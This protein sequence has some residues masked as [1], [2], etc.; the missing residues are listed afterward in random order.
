MKVKG[1]LQDVLGASRVTNA[2]RNLIKNASVLNVYSDPIR[3]VAKE[4]HPEP[5]KVTVVSVKDSIVHFNKIRFLDPVI[6]V[7]H[8][9]RVN[10]IVDYRSHI[11]IIDFRFWNDHHV[12]AFILVAIRYRKRNKTPEDG[13]VD[14]VLRIL[15]GIAPLLSEAKDKLNKI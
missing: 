11:V 14:D 10:T 13:S 2:R 12:D 1:F 6:S 15:E 4:V 7:I 8:C 5:F 3:E 9:E